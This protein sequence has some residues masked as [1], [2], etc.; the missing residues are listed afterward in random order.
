MIPYI[1]WAKTY[2]P[3]KSEEGNKVKLV[4]YY[5]NRYRE[6]SDQLYRVWTVDYRLN[7]IEKAQLFIGYLASYPSK[8]NTGAS[9]NIPNTESEETTL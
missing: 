5:L 3:Q 1:A 8:G 9:M 6:I 2:N 4:K 7:D